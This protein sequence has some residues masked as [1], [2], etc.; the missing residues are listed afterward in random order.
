MSPRPV[1]IFAGLSCSLSL[2][3][4]KRC[5]IAPCD[6]KIPKIIDLVNHLVHFS[7]EIQ[8]VSFAFFVLSISKH[9]EL[10]AIELRIV[11]L[12]PLIYLVQV[13]LVDFNILR[14]ADL[15]FSSGVID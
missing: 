11:V 5:I 12:L 8:C 1:N 10:A 13:F 9:K 14:V 6:S 4:I 2:Y 15:L 7:C 3:G